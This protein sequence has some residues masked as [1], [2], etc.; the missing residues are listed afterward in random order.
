VDNLNA[1]FWPS[2][3]ETFGEARDRQ[4]LNRVKF[5]DTPKHGTWLI[6]PEIEINV[7]DRQCTCGPIP[8]KKALKRN[9]KSLVTDWNKKGKNKMDI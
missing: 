1:H 4:L 6:M 9:L 7:T 5:I 8:D 3:I 2:S